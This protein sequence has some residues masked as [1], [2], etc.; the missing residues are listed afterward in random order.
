MSTAA[1][2]PERPDAIAPDSILPRVPNQE[3]TQDDPSKGTPE[4]KQQQAGLSDAAKRALLN[5]RRDYKLSWTPN[6]RAIV[7]RVLKAFEFLKGNAYPSFDPDGFQWYNAL[8]AATDGLGNNADPDLYQFNNNIYQMLALSFIAALSPQVPKCR[9]MPEN[10]DEEMDI[11]TARRAST[12]MS[13]IERK[14]NIQALQKQELLHLWTGG[15]YASY[16]RFVVDGDR[17]KTTKQPIIEPVD[18]QVLPDRFICPECGNV[19]PADSISPFSVAKCQACGHQFGGED[20]YE[21]E[22]LPIP[23]EVGKEDVPNGMTQV[24][25]FGAL[26]LDGAPYA[27]D[28]FETPIWDLE[29]ETDKAAV[30]AA[31]PGSEDAIR[32]VVGTN[33]MPDGER[34]R[35]ARI[36]QTSASGMRSGYLSTSLVTYS[37]CWIQKWAFYTIEDKQTRQELQSNF[38]DGCKLVS[39]GTEFL[40][41][42][43]AKLTDE[44]TW[45]GTLRGFGLYPIAVGDASLSVQ[46][47]I[48]DT[49]NTT[50]EH[51]DR[52]AS[53]TILVDED[54]IDGEAM[55]GESMPP[56]KLT[57]IK[58]KQAHMQKALQD[59]IYQP[60]FSIDPHIYTYQADLIQLAQLVSGV[61]PEIFGGSDKNVQT[62][63]GQRQMLNQAVGRLG[64][65]WDQI[66]EEHANRAENAV[67]SFAANM[68]E[69]VHNVIDGD[70]DSGFENEWVLLTEMQGSFHAYPESDQG[71]P[72]MA[73]EIRD[74]L[75]DMV[76]MA[77]KNPV[78]QA[79]L[80]DP[81]NQKTV[82]R[83]IL[84][85]EIKI[86]GDAARTKTKRIIA[87]LAKTE[88]LEVPA[89]GAAALGVVTNLP[90]IFLP[91][92][93]V[94][95]KLPDKDMDD[96]QLIVALCKEWAEKN[97]KQA[98]TNPGGYEN[99]RAYLRIASQF[100]QEQAVAP[101]VAAL[102]GAAASGAG[103][104]GT[105]AP[106][107][108][109]Q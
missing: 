101:A 16:T 70:T 59:L 54:A 60:T 5:L 86:T 94:G 39:V 82:A 100:A 69:K 46:E 1:L 18:T 65:F 85:P 35:L 74:R 11:A 13:L 19:T 34:D 87:E 97:W 61:R 67:K 26:H 89:E 56:G 62:A 28:L 45:C 92:T 9:Y 32:K 33:S 14:N 29:V 88:P 43:P 76:E 37:R 99:V 78:I 36:Q 73:A 30:I 51:M 53:P 12:M 102:Q 57:L 47:R 95:L 8:A 7:S 72:M 2:V 71:F 80:L 105:E 31:Y 91:Q 106:P 68:P 10:A 41:A 75:M 48:D 22:N 49:A 77:E 84:P 6:R 24:S 23:T 52:T 55:A 103:A 83:Y 4:E 17:F 81:D 44:W 42:V 40:D 58:R 109:P 104:P 107:A 79:Y 98:E 38:P 3:P 25:V 66:R 96:M 93:S 64:L 63:S 21:A 90:V 50:H 15:M 20:F 108:P 27:N